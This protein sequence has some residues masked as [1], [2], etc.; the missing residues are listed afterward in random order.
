MKRGLHFA[1]EGGFGGHR[2]GKKNGGIQLAGTRCAGAAAVCETTVP[3]WS[4]VPCP[5][6]TFTFPK[7]SV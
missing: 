6:L 4:M 2:I 1:M 5:A 3:S 7:T